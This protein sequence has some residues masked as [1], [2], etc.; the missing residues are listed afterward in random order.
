MKDARTDVA[1]VGLKGHAERFNVGVRSHHNWLELA[2][3]CV[4]GGS[5]YFIN[6]GLFTAVLTAACPIPIAFVLAFVVAGDRNFIWNR[7]WTFKIEHG[8]PHVQYARFLAVS[9]LA[10]AIDLAALAFLVEVVGLHK[11][12]RRGDSR[13]WSQRPS[14]SLAISSGASPRSCGIDHLKA[15]SR[16]CWRAAGAGGRRARADAKPQL[17]AARVIA[18]AASD[19]AVGTA[20]RGPQGHPLG[21]RVR[22]A[23]RDV[24]G[25][26]RAPRQAH[27][28]GL[29]QD[30]R[31]HQRD[32]EHDG[33]AEAGAAPADLGR[34]ITLA[35]RSGAL[36]SWIA[37]T[38]RRGH[39]NARQRRRVD[40]RVRRPRRRAGGG[41]PRQRHGDDAHERPHRAAGGLAAGPRRAIVIRAPGQPLGVFLPLCALFLGGLVDWR[42][43]FT[44]RTLDLL[45]LLSFGISLHWFNQGDVFI[46]TPLILPAAGLPAG[47]DDTAWAAATAAW[48]RHPVRCTRW[49]WWRC[50]SPWSASGW[51]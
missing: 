35:R 49:C 8:E 30:R 1:A 50:A 28:A 45:A 41:G 24:D 33:D 36:R 19:P 13:S 17:T 15:R 37:S 23:Q 4:V 20:A 29:V 38:R 32:P 44:M 31:L 47:Q 21:G 48:R 46:S 2:R 11:P 3:F 7:V 18:I 12:V 16:S 22:C 5:G 6:V 40:D 14:A 42:R 25:G 26:A 27:R 34:G 10:L 43:P 51:G 39:G 9:L